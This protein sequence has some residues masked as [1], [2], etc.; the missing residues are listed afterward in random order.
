[1]DT[2]SLSIEYPIDLLTCHSQ[3]KKNKNLLILMIHRFR[4]QILLQKV[5]EIASAMYVNDY[6]KMYDVTKSLR[7]CSRYVCA[8][9]IYYDCYFILKAFKEK[10]ADQMR[11]RFN[12]LIEN[13]IQFMF[14]S[15]IVINKNTSMKIHG[16]VANS[17]LLFDVEMVNRFLND[18]TVFNVQHPQFDYLCL[19]P[20]QSI[21]DRLSERHM[22]RVSPSST[23]I[24]KRML[25]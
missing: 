25:S 21:H 5:S 19:S 10:L 13:T 3:M 20:G 24:S 1:M 14:Y 12:R 16:R 11:N 18:Y 9:H 4:N 23:N 2:S 6:T 7:E 17:N 8:P 22:E 15:Q